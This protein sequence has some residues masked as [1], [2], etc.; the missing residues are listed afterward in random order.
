MQATVRDNTARQ[1][2]ELEIGGEVAFIDYHRDGRTVTLTHVE[3]P[4]ALRGQGLGTTLVKGMFALVRERN[5]RIIPVCPF[6]VRYMRWHPERT[7]DLLDDSQLGWP[8]P[9]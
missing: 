9:P 3:V 2:Y 6:I 1:R 5:D 4:L 7:E 8:R